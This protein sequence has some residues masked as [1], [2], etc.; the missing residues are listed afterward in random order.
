MTGLE[1]TKEF[2]AH[3]GRCERC[4][5]WWHASLEEI[6]L[7]CY[8]DELCKTGDRILRSMPGFDPAWVSSYGWFRPCFLWWTWL[9]RLVLRLALGRREGA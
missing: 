3:F 4:V 7:A 6:C 1:W 8:R 2:S 9:T 5:K